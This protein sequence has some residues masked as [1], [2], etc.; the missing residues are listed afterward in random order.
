ML[1]D[2]SAC[3]SKLANRRVYLSVVSLKRP[4]P[5]AKQYQSQLGMLRALMN[6]VGK[7]SDV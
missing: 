4:M 1:T 6:R 7:A 2:N 3:K 5:L